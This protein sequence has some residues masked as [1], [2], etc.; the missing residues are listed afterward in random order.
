[1]CCLHLRLQ[2]RKLRSFL[3]CRRS[4]NRDSVSSDNQLC[5]GVTQPSV[6]ERE[7]ISALAITPATA[8]TPRVKSV[9]LLSRRPMNQA[10]SV[11][12]DPFTS[13][14]I[15]RSFSPTNASRY[16]GNPRTSTIDGVT[17]GPGFNGP[18]LATLSSAR[19]RSCGGTLASS[20]P[21]LR[22]LLDPGGAMISENVEYTAPLRSYS[23]VSAEDAAMVQP[24][25][26]QQQGKIYRDTAETE[27][28]LPT[29]ETDRKMGREWIRPPSLVITPL[30]GSHVPHVSGPP[31]WSLSPIAYPLSRRQSGSGS[32]CWTRE[33]CL[34]HA[35]GRSRLA[36]ATRTAGGRWGRKHGHLDTLFHEEKLHPSLPPT[37]EKMRWD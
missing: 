33:F 15:A 23:P 14:R 24:I 2:E 37:A 16:V 6:G 5:A 32:R 26:R 18:F 27:R 11:P 4:G 31:V 35:Q 12:E 8:F 22:M 3:C 9:G 1:M 36:P 17:S 30:D 20:S 10:P 29:A 21:L 25:D 7:G 13:L 28:P 19:P 34:R